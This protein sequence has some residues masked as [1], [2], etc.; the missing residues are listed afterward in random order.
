MIILFCQSLIRIKQSTLSHSLYTSHHHQPTIQPSRLNNSI[1]SLLHQSYRLCILIAY[2]KSLPNKLPPLVN[3]TIN[4]PNS[5]QMFHDQ[6]FATAAID[7]LDV[8]IMCHH[9]VIVI[10]HVAR[11]NDHV[12]DQLVV[13]A[14]VIRV[15]T[16]IDRVDDQATDQVIDQVI[17]QIIVQVIDHDV[18]HK[19]YHQVDRDLDHRVVHQHEDLHHVNDHD[20]LADIR[21]GKLFIVDRHDM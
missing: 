14:V 16:M 11:L 20:I 17:N 21:A 6:I 1:H 7:R 15:M 13:P 4:Q 10:H 5:Q 8:S 19:V 2:N 9:I 3:Q 18:D 12:I